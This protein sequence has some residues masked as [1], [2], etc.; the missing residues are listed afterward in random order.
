[1]TATRDFTTPRDG[2]LGLRR[3]ANATGLSVATLPDGCLFAIEHELQDRRIMLNQ[4]LG[5]AVGGGIAR[6]YLRVGGASPLITAIAGSGAKV[7]FGA[8]ADRLVWEGETEGVGHR[9]TLWLA[10]DADAGFGM[11][12]YPT[13]PR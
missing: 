5:S 2:D 13:D 11:S 6:L 3:I 9:V 10:P 12:R 7:R 1:M 8:A 4:V